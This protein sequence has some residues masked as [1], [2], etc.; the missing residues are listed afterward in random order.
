MS[1]G[2]FFFKKGKKNSLSLQFF[3][4]RFLRRSQP[5]LF[6]IPLV[7]SLALDRLSC[8][9]RGSLLGL[10]LLDGLRFHL[11][12]DGRGLFCWWWWVVVLRGVVM[13]KKGKK[14]E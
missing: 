13:E 9:V 14:T 10:L 2:F 1:L 8:L 4:R 3:F 6:L 11:D 5:V 7:L 12:L